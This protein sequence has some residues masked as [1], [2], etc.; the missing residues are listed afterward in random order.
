MARSGANTAGLDRGVAARRRLAFVFH[1]FS[2]GAIEVAKAAQD[3]CELTWVIDTSVS[4]TE[5]MSQLL[6]R[7]GV[8]VDVAGM[9]S[10]NAAARIAENRPDGILALHDSLLNWTARVAE[11][12]ELPFHSPEVSARLTDKYLQRVA[13]RSA[14][15]P[16]P[17]FWPIPDA[18]DGAGWSALAADVRFPSLL[19]PRTGAG[20]RDVVPVGSLDE[21]RSRLAELAGAEGPGYVVEEYL[22]GRPRDEGQ[23]FAGYVSVESIVSKGTVSHLAITGR[24]PPAEPFRE[25]GFFI[26]SALGSDDRETVLGVATAAI[27]ALGVV[28]GGLHTEVKLT[29]DGPRVIEINGRVGGGTPAMLA[30]VTGV[31]LLPVVMRLALGETVIFDEIPPCSGVVFVLYR[32]APASMRQVAAVEGLDRLRSDPRV[33]RVILNRGPGQTVDWRD[34]NWGHVFSVHGVVENHDELKRLA[35]QIRAETEVRGE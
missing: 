9:S 8:V 33:D 28:T 3:L 13:L 16:V 4:D 24:T 1:P 14:G 30:A 32:H 11:R 10:E 26:P 7:L 6:R 35:R 15:L 12:L 20:S 27:A 17:G 29:P 25:T 19:K 21:L 34:G 2:F 22:P 5:L 31:D 18:D 23:E